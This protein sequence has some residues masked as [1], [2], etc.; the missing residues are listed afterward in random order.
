MFGPTGKTTYAEGK[1]LTEIKVAVGTG[2][3]LTRLPDG[4]AII[5]DAFSAVVKNRLVPTESFPCLI[6]RDYI[7]ASAGVLAKD[8]PDAARTLM[9][10]SLT[11]R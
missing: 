10:Q 4:P 7:L 9:D 11:R 3:A 8:M 2:G 6:D 1:D 5:R